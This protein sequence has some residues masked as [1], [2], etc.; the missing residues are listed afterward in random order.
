M[1]VTVYPGVEVGQGRAGQ[2]RGDGW[3]RLD[4]LGCYANVERSVFSL[5]SYTW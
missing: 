2:G 5:N 3:K 1:G 4:T